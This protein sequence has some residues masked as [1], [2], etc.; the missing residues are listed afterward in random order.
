MGHAATREQGAAASFA[1]PVAQGRVG[2]EQRHL[3]HLREP[4]LQLGHH[5]AADEAAARAQQIADAAQQ[6]GPFE[7]LGGEGAV[8]G[9]VGIEQVQA[10][11]GMGGGHTRHQ[12]EHRIHHQF[13]QQLAGHVDGAH[14]GIA[15]P[16]QRKQLPFLVVMGA[17]DQ[18]HQRLLHRERGHHQHIELA[19]IAV[20]LTAPVGL[21]LR[22]KL[23]E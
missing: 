14:A 7:Q 17:S 11:A 3:Q 23:P 20:V 12:L 19:A 2:A 8:G 6:G 18:G 1:A 5:K 21:Q 10:P 16:H 22:L 4:F 9:V 15:Q 13:R